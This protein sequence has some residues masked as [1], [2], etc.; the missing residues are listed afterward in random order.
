MISVES[1]IWVV[2]SDDTPKMD[3]QEQILSRSFHVARGIVTIGTMVLVSITYH[4]TRYL[5]STLIKTSSKFYIVF[6]SICV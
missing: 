2:F 1:N 4:T 5:K 6:C 3:S